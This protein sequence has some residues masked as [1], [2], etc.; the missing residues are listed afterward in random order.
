MDKL[1]DINSMNREDKLKFLDDCAKYSIRGQQI[2]I[3]NNLKKY[4]NIEDKY[5]TETLTSSVDVIK[6]KHF[7]EKQ[8]S[9]YYHGD[10]WTPYINIKRGFVKNVR[11]I[12]PNSYDKIKRIVLEIN[13][14]QIDQVDIDFID[15]SNMNY[16][17]EDCNDKCIIENFYNTKKICLKCERE[18]AKNDNYYKEINKMYYNDVANI[19]FD[20]VFEFKKNIIPM[21]ILNDSGLHLAYYCENRLYFNLHDNHNIKK[22]KIEYDYFYDPH[23]IDKSI[24]PTKYIRYQSANY[25]NT[26]GKLYLEN[27]IKEEIFT[28]SDKRNIE[29]NWELEGIVYGIVIKTSEKYNGEIKFIYNDP[30]LIN[31]FIKFKCVKS[32]KNI[33]VYTFTNDLRSEND[34]A[35]GYGNSEH[36]LKSKIIFDKS[37]F[38]ELPFGHKINVKVM[39]IRFNIMTYEDNMTCSKYYCM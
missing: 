27:R 36:W 14:T 22:I 5:Y 21:S 11:L 35:K 37:G 4:K 17:K 19:I 10:K 16:Y 25:H 26:S 1:V 2:E 13:G 6:S 29:L 24:F 15:V 7:R 18:N 9:N 12:E 38:G 23:F 3:Y 30:D 8:V 31:P 32:F 20:Y 28:I 34:H 39:I 33:N